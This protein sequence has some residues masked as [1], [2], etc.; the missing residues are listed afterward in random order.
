MDYFISGTF[1]CRDALMLSLW[2]T[3]K[4][5]VSLKLRGTQA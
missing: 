5:I 2:M 3:F 4:F 1:V